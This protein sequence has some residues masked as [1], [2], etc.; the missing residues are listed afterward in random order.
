MGTASVAAGAAQGATHTAA[1]QVEATE[2]ANAA[3]AEKARREFGLSEAGKRALEP[4]KT[5][6]AHPDSISGKVASVG[7][8]AGG[9]AVVTL[10]DG[11]VWAEIQANPLLVVKPGE[12][13]TIRKASLGSYMLV[14]AKRVATHVRRIK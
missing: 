14:S 8:R 6:E 1:P 9:E 3:A 11:Q 10:E 13:V 4:A 12:V 5:A 7:R 2:A